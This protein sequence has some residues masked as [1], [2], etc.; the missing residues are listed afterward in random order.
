MVSKQKWC[1]M[2]T[3]KWENSGESDDIIMSDNLLEFVKD[4]DLVKSF[5]QQEIIPQGRQFLLQFYLFIYFLF[6]Y[7]FVYLKCFFF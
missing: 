6:N 5:N 2:D 4:D 3:V 1:D 7:K